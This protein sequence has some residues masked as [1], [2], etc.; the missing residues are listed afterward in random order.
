MPCN[1]E[2]TNHTH[3]N[4]KI[5]V[6]GSKGGIMNVI[7]PVAKTCTVAG[8]TIVEITDEQALAAVTLRANRKQPY[9]VGGV[10]Q[11][12]PAPTP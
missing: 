8:A 1:Q 9:L 6:V 7:D 3:T 2:T 11:D 12:A 5:A 4:M 10:I